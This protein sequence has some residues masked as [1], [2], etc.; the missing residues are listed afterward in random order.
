MTVDAIREYCLSF[1]QAKENLQWGDDLC[2]KIGGKIFTIVGL[3]NPRLCFKCS[4]EV[5]AELIEREDIRPA[6]YVG[7]YKWVMLDRIDAVGWDEL[8]EL[9]RQ[10]YEMV[11]AKAPKGKGK[12]SAAKKRSAATKVRKKKLKS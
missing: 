5:F 1:Q 9:I 12:K 7:R 4:P 10:S 6:P 3:D 2:F 8:R 11:A